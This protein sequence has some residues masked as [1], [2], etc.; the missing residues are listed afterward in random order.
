CTLKSM[1]NTFEIVVVVVCLAAVLAIPITGIALL[2]RIRLSPIAAN[3]MSNHLS[4][5]K[6]FSRC[7]AIAAIYIMTAYQGF[8][9]YLIIVLFPLSMVWLKLRW[10]R[11]IVFSLFTWTFL[12]CV[13][14]LLAFVTIFG[15]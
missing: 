13:N 5:V 2:C 6:I 4:A 14:L 10:S 12:M 9:G 15:G 7:M 11:A 3:V 8:G 1:L